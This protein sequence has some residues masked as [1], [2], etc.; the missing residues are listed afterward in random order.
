[1][2]GDREREKEQESRS[3][4]ITGDSS[5][6][7]VGQSIGK[8]VPVPSFNPA[9]TSVPGR[10]SRTYAGVVAGLPA[11][12]LPKRVIVG[13]SPVVTRSYAEVTRSPVV[14][15]GPVTRSKAKAMVV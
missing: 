8:A 11:W 12:E 14:S 7:A 2:G 5:Q 1:V 15:K 6:R 13:D 4:I 10:G 9:M 3:G